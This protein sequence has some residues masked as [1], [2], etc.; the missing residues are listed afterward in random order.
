MKWKNS[1]SNNNNNNSFCVMTM[2]NVIKFHITFI[3]KR[4]RTFCEFGVC[5]C[6]GECLACECVWVWM[7]SIFMTVSLEAFYL[8]GNGTPSALVLYQND[9]A[10]CFFLFSLLFYPFQ[11]TL[12]MN[13]LLQFLLWFSFVPLNILCISLA[14]VR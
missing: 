14:K 9:F 10:F 7:S 1:N 4:F 3:W 11:N 2:K 5:Q 12:E 13:V 8:L 6:A